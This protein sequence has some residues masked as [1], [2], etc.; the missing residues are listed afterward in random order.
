MENVIAFNGERIQR[1]IQRISS[2]TRGCTRAY[3]LSDGIYDE[4]NIADTD[5]GSPIKSMIRASCI[6]TDIYIYIYN[7]RAS[8]MEN[9]MRQSR[10]I[11]M[12][13]DRNNRKLSVWFQQR[14]P[15]L[16][17]HLRRVSSRISRRYLI[18]QW[19]RV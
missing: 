3:V 13:L 15:K 5:T 1:Y 2:H 7:D 12:S 16:P 8:L 14:H 18:E 10:R 17:L 19:T 6:C 4:I 9:R 11:R